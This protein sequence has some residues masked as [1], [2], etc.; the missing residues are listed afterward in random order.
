[1]KQFV[2]FLFCITT[3]HA[4]FTL[5]SNQDCTDPAKVFKA[6]AENGCAM[7]KVKALADNFSGMGK[8]SIVDLTSF[9]T[10]Y[11]FEVKP[12]VMGCFQDQIK[13]C[14]KDQQQILMDYAVNHT[15]A[16]CNAGD[17][18]VRPEVLEFLRANVF[19]RDISMSQCCKI[20]FADAPMFNPD[21]KDYASLDFD[22]YGK[23]ATK[24]FEYEAQEVIKIARKQKKTC[25]QWKFEALIRILFD[26][27]KY[28]PEPFSV[29]FGLNLAKLFRSC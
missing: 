12:A 6:W 18:Q 20:S 23:A 4:V 3:A 15:S 16:I 9:A 25:K 14:L 19:G 10:R 11:C 24:V 5:K 22:Q 7:N 21:H 28:R 26:S 8:V 13:V 17:N 29:Q 1:M 27:D 2:A